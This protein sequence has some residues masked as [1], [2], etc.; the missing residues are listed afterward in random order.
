[1]IPEKLAAEFIGRFEPL[2]NIGGGA[3][4][5]AR[6]QPFQ[7]AFS[8]GTVIADDLEHH[9]IVHMT[10]RADLLQHATNFKIGVREKSRIH[11]H[12]PG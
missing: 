10:C 3:R 12:L 7:T 11:F 5:R 1:M 2:F 9:G 8:A 6:V 4:Y